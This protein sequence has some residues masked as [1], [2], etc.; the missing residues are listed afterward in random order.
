[1]R[2]KAGPRRAIESV[3]AQ[4]IPAQEV[5]VVDDGSDDGTGEVAASFEQVRV[6]RQPNGGPGA[7]RNRGFAATTGGI[8]A[9]QDADDVAFPRRLELSARHL[10]ANPA[11]GAVLGQQEVLVEEGARVP[12][13]DRGSGDGP[14]R[15]GARSGGLASLTAHPCTMAVR[16]EVFEQV[17]PFDETM[18][19]GEDTDWLL[20]VSEA[21]HGIGRLADRA[22]RPGLLVAV[23]DAAA[24][25]VVRRELDL[26][27]VAG[28]DA[29]VVAA[30]L[31]RDVAE[32]LVVVVEL[33]AEHR[34]GE[35]LGDLAL[36]LDLLFFAHAAPKGSG[37]SGQNG[38]SG[39]RR[40]RSATFERRLA[41][42]VAEEGLDRVLEVLGFEQPA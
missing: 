18:R 22:R 8:V 42:T 23:G 16:R 31:A 6:I 19:H 21:G 28:Q 27:A 10:S 34:V 17:G 29:D 40:G 15:E 11:D 2:A 5:V 3:L 36:H 12:F 24:V 25:E 9:F 41:G 37:G 20:R 39:A 35:G 4:T 14:A 32:D 38:G 13:W 30:H 7:A 26:D 33:D 1:M